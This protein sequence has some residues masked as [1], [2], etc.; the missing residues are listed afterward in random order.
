METGQ[1]ILLCILILFVLVIVKVVYDNKVKQKKL[2]RFFM[3][4]YG[5][6]PNNDYTAGRYDGLACYYNEKI[7]GRPVIDDITWNDLDLETIFMIM[8][9]TCSGIG[10]E[11]LYALLHMPYYEEAPLKERDRII[12]YFD[13]H[14]DER[15]NVQMELKKLGKL[16]NASIG[17]YLSGIKSMKP[18]NPAFH[19]SLLVLLFISV[20]GCLSNTN[21]FVP[22]LIVMILVNFI[23]YFRYKAKISSYFVVFSYLS[24]LTQTAN[25]IASLKCSG[26][27]TYNDILLNC[28][29]SLKNISRYSWLFVSGTDFRSDL[30]A[31]VL[32]YVKMITHFDL[33]IFDRMVYSIYKYRDKLD[34]MMD[35]LGEID[36]DIAIGSYRRYLGDVCKP[37]FV[38]NESPYIHCENV[39]HPLIINPVKNSIK[40]DQSVL[41]TGSNASGKSTF[42]KTVA[43]N[44]ILAQTIYTCLADSWQGNFYRI[45]SSMALTDNISGNESYYIVEIKSLKRIIDAADIKDDVPVL[46]FIDEVLRGTNTVE[47]I[48][49]SSRILHALNH[50][51]ALCFAATHDIEL[52]TI[53]ENEY[54]NYHFKEDVIDHQVIFDYHLRH[55]RAT[56]RNAIKLL[57][58]L[59]FET[60]IT[61]EAS[62]AAKNF[63]EQGFWSIISENQVI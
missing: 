5:K 46:C 51:N 62:T 10:E 55:G 28:S 36:A 1:I 21:I 8:N 3:E 48:A 31:L 24:R 29:S 53:L 2:R 61:N 9:N 26:I 45:Y 60:K 12:S 13:E 25:D 23:T 59:G 44:A 33:I 6:L 54:S 14:E 38:S 19:I 18:H 15:V 20:F 7:K 56:S 30:I 27:K 63:E 17:Q 42:L 35:I 39:Y 41:I 49:A 16:Q 58:I 57:D 47:R 34:Q 50:K 32:D 11:Y 40:E 4:N 37:T 43:I 22:M 52:T